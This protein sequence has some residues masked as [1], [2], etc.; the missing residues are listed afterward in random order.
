MAA[1]SVVVPLPLQVG[2]SLVVV[3]LPPVVDSLEEQPQL[4]QEGF[5]AALLPAAGSLAV[6]VLLPVAVDSLAVALR[7]PPEGFLVA[8]L[9]HLLVVYL[10]AALQPAVGCLVALHLVVAGYLAALLPLLGA[11]CL[12][13]VLPQQVEDSS[14]VRQPAVVAAF[15]VAAAPLAQLAVVVVCLALPLVEDCSVVSQVRPVVKAVF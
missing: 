12:A 8:E 11:G 7:R 3:Q 6:V 10:V 13:A 4:Q 14:A 2:G 15:S 1:S 9:R 5:S